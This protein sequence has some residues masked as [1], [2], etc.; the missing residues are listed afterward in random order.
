MP[1]F[2]DIGQLPHF[3]SDIQG[4]P[5]VLHLIQQV[6]SADGVVIVTPEYNYSVPGPL[7]NALDWA[8]RPAMQSC[9]K[10]K[11]VFVISLSAGAT[12]GVRAQSHLKYI[13]NGMLAQ[14]YTTPE[15]VV[16]HALKS[17]EDGIF[18]N[19]DIVNF[20]LERLGD[21]TQALAEGDGVAA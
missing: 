12:G 1:T 14:V 9:F 2:A 3:N 17:V 5:S 13:L 19:E 21:F 8:S 11:P 16:P 6:S 18:K 7:K 20:A 15:V 4:D 10:G